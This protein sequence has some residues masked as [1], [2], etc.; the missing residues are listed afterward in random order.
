MVKL[1]LILNDQIKT[2]IIHIEDKEFIYK[3]SRLPCWRPFWEF[4]I[5]SILKDKIPHVKNFSRIIAIQKLNID[6]DENFRTLPS[7]KSRNQKSRTVMI[8]K[9][10]HGKTFATAISLG[11]QEHFIFSIVYQLLSALHCAQIQLRFTDYD[12]HGN[13]ILLKKEKNSN[14]IFYLYD[15][16]KNPTL[17]PSF[18][19]RGMIIDYEFAFVQDCINKRYDSGIGL[20]GYYYYF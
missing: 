9:L 8:S 19:Y 15:L 16:T 4:Y 12:I 6:V 20:I 13:N 11:I 7:A 2:G 3:V 10:I 18:G 5:S 1:I 14:H 17:I